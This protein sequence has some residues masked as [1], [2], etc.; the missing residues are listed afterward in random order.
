MASFENLE[1]TPVYGVIASLCA[2]CVAT[3]SVLLPLKLDKV[4]DSPWYIIFTPVHTALLLLPTLILL[5]VFLGALG[6]MAVRGSRLKDLISQLRSKAGTDGRIWIP[7]VIHLAPFAAFS[8]VLC[9]QLDVNVT[10]RPVYLGV[11]LYIAF[12]SGLAFHVITCNLAMAS[13]DGMLLLQSTFVV[14]RL[15]HVGL[16]AN[17]SWAVLLI[18]FW[19]LCAGCLIALARVRTEGSGDT[20]M[21]ALN[22]TN[23]SLLGNDYS[24]SSSAFSQPP[25]F[26]AR[27]IAVSPRFRG[28]IAIVVLLIAAATVMLVFRL[29]GALEP[30]FLF[31]FAPLYAAQIIL[32]LPI[33]WY[34]VSACRVTHMRRTNSHI[35][36]H[37]VSDA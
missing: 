9:E 30:R 3:F 33:F 12:V 1:L 6:A 28:I 37:L 26:D 36:E 23:L 35:R 4:I 31:V 10:M 27:G 21:S 34:A 14:G 17:A 32:D 22:A 2:V 13:I 15:E 11:P 25:A 20:P 16:V 7:I 5:L 18:P 24:S 19:L 29:D 8:V